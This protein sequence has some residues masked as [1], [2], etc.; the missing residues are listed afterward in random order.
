M[1]RNYKIL[2][3]SD[4]QFLTYTV[5]EW[6]D[7][8]SRPEYKDIVVES[9][10]YCQNEKGLLLYAW[11]I[12]SNHVHL[13]A[14]AAEG[15]KLEHIMRDH[16]KH[17]A[18]LLMNAIENN[19]QES[20]REWMLKHFMKDDGSRQFWIRDLHP[21]WLRTPAVIDKYVDYIHRNPVVQGLV[22]EPQQSRT[23]AL[24]RLR[25]RRAC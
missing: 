3:Q 9:L 13:I 20:R 1:S 11:V 2:D 4:L 6:V 24:L 17:T 18:K 22:F 25:E 21:I 23:Q 12:M 8:L 14:C 7:V 16:K 10:K 15:Q 5:V 19:E